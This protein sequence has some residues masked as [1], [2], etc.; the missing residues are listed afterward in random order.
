MS[1]ITLT[2][3]ANLQNE[4]TA[5]NA[6]NTNNTI[7]E[8]AL[9]NTLSRDGTQPN[10]MDATL[11]M[12]SNPIINL[13]EPTTQ[14]SPIRVIDVET[15][16]GGGTINVSPLPTGGTTGQSLVK[17][18][19][20]DYDVIWQTISG[21][22]AQGDV[23]IFDT[24]NNAVISQLPLIKNNLIV[25]RYDT[26]WPLANAPFIRGSVSG[27]NAFQDGL[28]NYW[29]LDLSSKT[30]QAAWF[31][32]GHGTDDAVQLQKLAD[33]SAGKT[34]NLGS[35]ALNT[36]A[37]IRL[38]KTGSST[39]RG[40]GYNTCSITTL[41]ASDLYR[42]IFYANNVV[43]DL[44]FEGINFIGNNVSTV[45]GAAGAIFVEQDIL[46]LGATGKVIIQNN[47][48]YNFKQDLWISFI[49]GN[50]GIYPVAE[51]IIKDNVWESVSGNSRSYSDSFN[52]SKM[53]HI[54]GS[55]TVPSCYI[56]PITISGNNFNC[57]GVTG[58]TAIWQNT[59]PYLIE[60]NIVT[61]CCY[62]I[63][64]L[65][66]VYTFLNY[67]AAGTLSKGGIFRNNRCTNT[68]WGG[69]YIGPGAHLYCASSETAIV[70]GNFLTGINRSDSGTLRRGGISL[71]GVG[72]TITAHNMIDACVTGI[73]ISAATADQLFFNGTS[74]HKVADNLVSG[75]AGGSEGINVSWGDSGTFAPYVVLQDNI[76]NV[77]TKVVATPGTYGS[78]VNNNT[79]P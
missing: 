20:T 10:A 40:D 5:V 65:I 76:C 42:G 41:G 55:A 60:N 37:S 45:V 36:S 8:A 33:V 62:N 29:E 6:I 14:F 27:P 48:F 56:G 75:N 1:K 79:L 68:I 51:V 30:I 16:N 57:Y 72:R 44:T 24:L 2:D 26:G 34:V 3:L 63:T 23:V 61:E 53:I 32:V 66:N 54:W 58:C 9:D 71:N 28:G 13:P 7:L 74:Q 70:Q 11:D 4:T 12:N 49:A 21:G 18:T 46:S 64:A 19:N 77:T 52:S 35:L 59:G 38:A 31:W 73:A 17:Q 22:S 25:T 47:R 67:S 50:A 69:G 39:W 43:G 15:L 78:I